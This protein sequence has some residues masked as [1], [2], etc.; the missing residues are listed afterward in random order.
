[1]FPYLIHNPTSP[2]P[3]RPALFPLACPCA[4][5]GQ[6]V[7]L[8]RARSQSELQRVFHTLSS[9]PEVRCLLLALPEVPTA[10]GVPVSPADLRQW[11]GA[12]SA[13]SVC[14]VCPLLPSRYPCGD[15]PLCWSHA[16]SREREETAHLA[17]LSSRSETLDSALTTAF[18]GLTARNREV[19]QA[20]AH[21]SEPDH[22]NSPITQTTLA[23]TFHLSRRQ[24]VRILLRARTANPEVYA[25]LQALRTHR[26]KP[27]G[28]YVCPTT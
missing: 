12:L 20:W 10:L 19:L 25:R 27:T 13:R 6:E 5:E 22:P 28:R 11:A 7:L 2:R 9:R 1:M 17:T 15:S 8:L 16:P 23:R 18:P 4:P 14:P 24:I 21:R 3:Q 26:L